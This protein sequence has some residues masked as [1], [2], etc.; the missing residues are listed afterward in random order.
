M[1]RPAGRKPKG[2]IHGHM[3]KGQKIGEYTYKEIEIII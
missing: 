2:E 1:K 3:K